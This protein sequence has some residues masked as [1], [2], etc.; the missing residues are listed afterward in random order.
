MLVN[1]EL[2]IALPIFILICVIGAFQ[3]RRRSSQA[4]QFYTTLPCVGIREGSWLA[5]TRGILSSITRSADYALAG[6]QKYSGNGLPFVVPSTGCGAI[7]V[8]SPSQLHVLNKSSN[9]VQAIQA[10][11]ESHQPRYTMGDQAA[12][13]DMLHFDLVR[14][15]L[16]KNVGFFASMTQDELSAALDDYCGNSKEWKTVNA[17]DFCTK[18]IA[19]AGNRTYVGLPLCRNE[20][21]LE[22]SRLYATAVYGAA[23]VITALP[24]FIRPVLGHLVSLPAQRYLSRCKKVLVPFV[25]DRLDKLDDGNGDG[26]VRS[27]ISL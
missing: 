3:K 12:Y 11:F 7:V 22:Q 19:R 13:A 23:A 6:Y 18:V 26:P 1:S 10:Q 27:L 2:R 17:W 8:L 4:A 25:Q 9:E 24:S 21:L 5:W 20:E 16:T 14:N 15:Q